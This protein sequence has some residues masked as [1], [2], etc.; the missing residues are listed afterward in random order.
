MAQAGTGAGSGAE[1]D[2]TKR[3][4]ALALRTEALL[5][6][7]PPHL[8][9]E[10]RRAPPTSPGCGRCR[11]AGTRSLSLRRN[12]AAARRRGQALRGPPTA[13]ASGA[14]ACRPAPPST[15]PLA[16]RHPG[17]RAERSALALN[18]EEQGRGLHRRMETWPLNGSNV[19]Q[20]PPVGSR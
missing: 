15:S 18:S 1:P 3:P 7:A 6:P 11:G 8:S 19:S 20:S 16:R 13:G 10:A 4:D 12:R 14:M 5:R 9:G 17:S 2:A